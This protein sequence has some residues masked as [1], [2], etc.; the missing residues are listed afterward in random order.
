[1]KTHDFGTGKA[2]SGCGIG[3]A[4]NFRG[5][6]IG[7][8]TMLSQTRIAMR[9]LHRSSETSSTFFFTFSKFLY[10]SRFIRKIQKK[11]QFSDLHL[12]NSQFRIFELT[13]CNDAIKMS[14]MRTL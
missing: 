2:R 3:H 5:L 13:K 8:E 10:F 14:E 12:Q 6:S 11:P 4:R 9:G 1:M 7:S